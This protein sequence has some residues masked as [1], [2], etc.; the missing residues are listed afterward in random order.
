MGW[1]GLPQCQRWPVSCLGPLATFLLCL[2][3]QPRFEAQSGSS[4]GAAS[5]P[6]ACA[7]LRNHR[8]DRRPGGAVPGSQRHAAEGRSRLLPLLHPLRVPE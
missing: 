7:L 2:C 6:G 4:W 8:A 1:A 5:L 3:S